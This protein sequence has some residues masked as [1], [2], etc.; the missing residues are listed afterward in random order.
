MAVKNKNEGDKPIESVSSINKAYRVPGFNEF[1]SKF[2]DKEEFDL[3]EANKEAVL[4]RFEVFRIFPEVSRNLKAVISEKLFEDLGIRPEAADLKT[5][6]TALE[7]KLFEK[8]DLPYLKNLGAQIENFKNLP[9]QVTELELELEALGSRENLVSQRED[10]GRDI[11]KQEA[12]VGSAQES[13]ENSTA[14]KERVEQIIG[15]QKTVAQA[16]KVLLGRIKEINPNAS[17]YVVLQEGEND[18]WGDLQ[19]DLFLVNNIK[20]DLERLLS[21]P[22]DRTP[23]LSM[24][25][26]FSDLVSAEA[27][28]TLKGFDHSLIDLAQGNDYRVN[29]DQFTA[30]AGYSQKNFM[31]KLFV[32]FKSPEKQAGRKLADEQDRLNNLKFLREEVIGRIQSVEGADEELKNVQAQYGSA[33]EM[34]FLEMG[35]VKQVFEKVKVKSEQAI[36]IK[37]ESASLQDILAGQ[38]LIEQ[39]ARAR[40]KEADLY[41]D[42]DSDDEASGTMY[43]N[44]TLKLLR[45]GFE[46]ILT[47]KVSDAVAKA[48]G[49]LSDKQID[50]DNLAVKL[51]SFEIGL[52]PL[53]KNEK[54]IKVR[55]AALEKLAGKGSNL[56]GA[57]KIALRVML[58]EAAG[59]KAYSF[60]WQFVF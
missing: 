39:L 32:G 51:K 19:S 11:T 25:E 21:D 42:M 50:P 1:L 2:K 6:D 38:G 54:Y 12:K 40:E 57:K 9:Q 33:R 30:A 26:Y 52:G 49:S 27:R 35:I 47:E 46:G 20:R 5:I 10:L 15:L 56:S 60:D 22:T 23:V 24:G 18:N 31:K 16:E 7:D 44:N 14:A 29:K 59:K 28:N 41:G 13:K 53:A 17:K 48:I 43:Q 58:E 8:L 45:A 3:S 37:M 55:Q 4:E 34:L 36:N